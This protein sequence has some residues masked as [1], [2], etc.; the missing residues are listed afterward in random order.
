MERGIPARN[1]EHN[2]LNM[3]F[4]CRFN[5]FCHRA[6]VVVTAAPDV[7]KIEDE[8]IDAAQH[9]RSWFAG[10]TVELVYRQSGH[11][12]SVGTNVAAGL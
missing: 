6:D 3:I 1:I 5:A 12:I 2:E 4:C 10:G 7:L 8:C 11:R 9:R